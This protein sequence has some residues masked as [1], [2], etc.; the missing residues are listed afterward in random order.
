ST[1]S[2]AIDGLRSNASVIAKTANAG[3]SAIA[4]KMGLVDPAES[5]RIAN[6]R[7]AETLDA[8]FPVYLLAGSR[9]DASSIWQLAE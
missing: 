4:A 1:L 8:R 5:L 3:A 9:S 6:E 2:S 7:I